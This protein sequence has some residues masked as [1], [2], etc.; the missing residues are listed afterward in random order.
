MTERDAYIAKMRAE[1]DAIDARIKELS[2]KTNRARADARVEMQHKLDD[3]REKRSE[4]DE[5][6]EALRGASSQAWADVKTGFEHAW[7]ELKSS[8]ESAVRRFD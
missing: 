4:L 8:V 3:L 1:I 7:G 2:A 5:R 6:M